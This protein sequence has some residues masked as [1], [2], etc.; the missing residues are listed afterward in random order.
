MAID[1]VRHFSS[2]YAEA[3][4]KFLDAATEAGASVETF[5]NVG[6]NGP[7]GEP[8]YTDVARLGPAPG[9]ARAVLLPIPAHMALKVIADQGPRSVHCVKTCWPTCQT[10][11]RWC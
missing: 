1:A 6:A 11:L 7:M 9:Q 8:L 5:Q 2:T 4:K 10:G 3:R